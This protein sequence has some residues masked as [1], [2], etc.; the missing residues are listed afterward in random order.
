MKV[1]LLPL[2]S[3]AA[4]ALLGAC[5][6]RNANPSPDSPDM[7]ASSSLPDFK[8]EVVYGTARHSTAGAAIVLDEGGIVYV[9]GR[10]AW[11]P[12]QLGLRIRAT[13]RLVAALRLPHATVVASG[14][15]N[16]GVTINSTGDNWLV[17]H[18]WMFEGPDLAPWRITITDGSG[19]ITTFTQRAGAPAMWR[20][21]P[22]KSA[23]SSSAVYSGG[24][25]ESGTLTPPLVGG[26][27]V[28]ARLAK[29]SPP[30]RERP[31]GSFLV[32]LESAQERRS[33]VVAGRDAI[34]LRGWL[35]ALP[36][37]L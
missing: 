15:W 22:V 16:H 23:K 31:E 34:P 35:E 12:E 32:V 29:G 3:L 8:S 13:G 24:S 9:L 27:W 37:F 26:L 25:P 2:I 33:V 21:S 30:D 14:W 28:L 18:K 11:R 4:A 1:N 7:T 10:P 5:T 20:Y 36:G 6:R 17:A 19:N